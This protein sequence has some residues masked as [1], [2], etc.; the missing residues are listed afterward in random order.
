MIS[1]LL[2]A[3]RECKGIHLCFDNKLFSCDD[4][5]E[6]W[7]ESV[8]EI[9]ST[10]DD[11]IELNC[12]ACPHS[13]NTFRRG[14]GA[15]SFLVN[16]C[17]IENPNQNEILNMIKDLV[18]SYRVLDVEEYKSTKHDFTDLLELV[19]LWLKKEYLEESCSESNFTEKF[20]AISFA[21]KEVIEPEPEE[22]FDF[23]F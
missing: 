22:D 11:I 1:C 13:E 10:I 4:L 6:I 23:F 9:T 8:L 17:P 2:N 19:N 21:I 20:I 14:L 3:D 7:V 12:V 15:L 5:D 18:A 16:I